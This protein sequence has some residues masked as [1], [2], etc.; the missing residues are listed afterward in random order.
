MWA[1]R[2][3]GALVAQG[4]VIVERR[5]DFQPFHFDQTIRIRILSK[6]GQAAAELPDLPEN[7]LFLEGQ[8]TYPDGRVQA[9]QKRQDFQTRTVLSPRDGT[10]ME[11][12]LLPPGLTADCVVDLYWR[13]ATARGR[14]NQLRLPLKDH[15]N[16]PERCGIFWYTSLGSAFPTRTVTVVRSRELF[17]PLTMLGEGFPMQRGSSSQGDTFTFQDL[18]AAPQSP[19]SAEMNRPCPKVLVYRPLPGA[20]HL[21]KAPPEAYWQKV[22]DMH[23]RNWFMNLVTKWSAYLPFSKEIRKDLAGGPREKARTIAER[24]N[25]RVKNI[26]QLLFDE[27]PPAGASQQVDNGLGTTDLDYAA[28]T[29]FSDNKGMTRLLFH[30]LLEEG[31][32]PRVALV[33]DRR[34]WTASPETRTPFQFSGTLLVV[35]EP[36]KESLWIDPIDRLTPPGMVPNM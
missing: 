33:A 5:L 8:V 27:K 7:L 16:L 6:A 31:L 28:R 17:W 11:G 12:V 19:Y 1:L 34:A 14:A 30:L 15:G 3:D 21:D 36:G 13:E 20:E 24:L 18:P 32:Q 25:A 26:D 29:G 9:I 4:A 23:H 22:A 10:R 2:D 35:D